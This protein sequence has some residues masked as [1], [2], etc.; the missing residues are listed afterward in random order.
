[1]FRCSTSKYSIGL[2]IG[3]TAM[4]RYRCPAARLAVHRALVRHRPPHPSPN[5]AAAV[6]FWSKIDVQRPNMW[7]TIHSC[8]PISALTSC[9]AHHSDCSRL[10]P[11]LVKQHDSLYF[12]RNH[13]QESLWCPHPLHSCMWNSIIRINDR[14][15]DKNQNQNK[16]DIESK[17]KRQKRKY[18]KWESAHKTK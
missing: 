15:K 3:K 18:M 4:L 17:R 10:P 9:T 7:N 1:M 6:R 8:H 2:C 5:L 11:Q 12:A 16:K 13:V 14:E